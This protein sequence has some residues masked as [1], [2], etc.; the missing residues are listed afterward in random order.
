VGDS[1]CAAQQ[2][3]EIVDEATAEPAD[4]LPGK[5][6]QVTLEGLRPEP[7][8]H[9]GSEPVSPG[10]QTDDAASAGREQLVREPGF[11]HAGIAAHDDNAEAAGRGPGEFSS[12]Q[13][14]L[15]VATDDALAHGVGAGGHRRIM[16][17]GDA[18]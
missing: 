9:R 11:T 1:G 7:E 14:E 12:E 5:P 18:D 3:G 10:P 16:G 13:L 6:A 2:R 15:T 4:P 17:Y 8:R